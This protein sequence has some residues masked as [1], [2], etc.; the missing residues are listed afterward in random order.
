MKWKF[1]LAVLFVALA[2]VPVS[3]DAA[4]PEPFLFGM[5]NCSGYDVGDLQALRARFDAWYGA[6]H[7]VVDW[8]GSYHARMNEF[9]ASLGC[10]APFNGEQQLTLPYRI[11]AEWQARVY[12][13]YEAQ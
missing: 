12:Q 7:Q 6:E 4:P 13:W 5:V 2:L 11:V 1:A 8:S 3:V 9:A 10:P